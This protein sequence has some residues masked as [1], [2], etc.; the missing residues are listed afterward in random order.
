VK[1]SLFLS[2]ESSTNDKA[3]RFTK[4]PGEC[5]NFGALR[6]MT[7]IYL[8]PFGALRNMTS[9]YLY[10]LTKDMKLLGFYHSKTSSRSL[11]KTTA[12]EDQNLEGAPGE[13]IL[14]YT[15]G[16]LGLSMSHYLALNTRESNIAS[17]KFCLF[18]HRKLSFVN[19]FGS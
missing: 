10:P 6:N 11:D 18:C 14:H 19:R 15:N 1:D 7:S 16:V 5:S 8:Y 17:F 4:S 2:I 3:M 9:I 12:E 13:S